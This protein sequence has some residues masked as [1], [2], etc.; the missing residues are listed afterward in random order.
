M[1]NIL[2][3]QQENDFHLTTTNHCYDQ[4]L[5]KGCGPEFMEE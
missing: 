3:S 4:K 2:I 5:F 1:I